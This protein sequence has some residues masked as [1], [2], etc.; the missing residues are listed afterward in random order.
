MTAILPNAI[1]NRRISVDAPGNSGTAGAGMMQ[2]VNF[3]PNSV[4]FH[5]AEWLEVGHGPVGATGYFADQIAAGTDL[6]HHP[7]PDFLRI[8]ADNVLFDHAFL[9]N[10]PSPFKAGRYHWPI[11]N[12]FRRAATTGAGT[13][14]VNTTQFFSM[15]ADGTITVSKQGASVTGGPVP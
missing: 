10:F 6:D 7:T 14:S 11:P 5:N 15:A 4:N 1:R 13:V 9:I 3:L 8:R 12:R 2:R